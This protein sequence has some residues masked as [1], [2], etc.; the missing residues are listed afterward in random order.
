MEVF[1]SFMRIKNFTLCVFSQN[2]KQLPTLTPT[3]KQ[4]Q[5]AALRLTFPVSSGSHHRAS[6]SEW[7]PVEKTQAP[8]TA[9]KAMRPTTTQVVYQFCFIYLFAFFTFFF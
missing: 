8:P 9:T 5:Q 1:V 4:A 6:E 7:V 3:E 2:A